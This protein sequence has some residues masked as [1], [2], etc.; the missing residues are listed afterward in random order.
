[1]H[2]DPRPKTLGD[3]KS[4]SERFARIRLPHVAP[5]T[6]LVERIRSDRDCGDAVPYFDPEDGGIDARCLFLLEAPGPRAIE[7]GL[8]SRDNPDESA[9]NSLLLHAEAGIPRKQ[10]V[11]WNIVPWYVGSGT[12]IRPVRVSD[13]QEASP[14][15]RAVFELL[16]RLRGI[17]LVGRK[18]QKA[19]RLIKAERSNLPV[20]A[21]PHPSPQFVNRSP[22]N[23]GILLAAL[24]TV[25]TELSLIEYRHDR[26]PSPG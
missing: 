6:R 14:Y 5:L 10:T 2:D 12:K 9:K 16:P 17:V 22:E 23:R 26:P 20:Y 15:L 19:E 24:R 21:M 18:A 4:R 11:L 1:M 7:S 25:A 8:I 13:I 3:P